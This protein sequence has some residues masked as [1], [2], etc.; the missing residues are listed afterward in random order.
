[1][2]FFRKIIHILACMCYFVIGL[3]VIVCL[4][5]IIKYKPIVVLSGSM[6][7]T[8]KVGSIIYYKPVSQSEIK[9]NDIITFKM[10][11]SLVTHRVNQIK[12]NTYITKGDANDSVDSNPVTYENVKGK[13]PQISVT[14]LGYGVR[15]INE[16]MYV[17]LIF[18]F[19]LL[20]EFLL[21]NKNKESKKSV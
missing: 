14:Y 19:I 21:S 8:F 20:L 4:P 7:P 13:V 9:V 6:E 12:N 10:G 15:F 2:D 5:L 17:F 18:I 3:Y 11:N 1:M 16:N